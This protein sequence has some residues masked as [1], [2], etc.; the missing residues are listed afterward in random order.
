MNEER[1]ESPVRIRSSP[2]SQENAQI[3]IVTAIYESGLL[4]VCTYRCQMYYSGEKT[5]K[6][7][8]MSETRE[9]LV[10]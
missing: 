6:H 1:V 8:A 4:D 3:F 5:S 10:S 2:K 9:G 7:G